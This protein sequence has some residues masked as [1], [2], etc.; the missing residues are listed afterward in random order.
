ML[1]RLPEGPIRIKS[2]WAVEHEFFSKGRI[3][4]APMLAYSPIKMSG[5]QA[6]LGQ[7]GPTLSGRHPRPVCHEVQH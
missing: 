6:E 3:A 2:K 7:H 1:F 5:P 4:L